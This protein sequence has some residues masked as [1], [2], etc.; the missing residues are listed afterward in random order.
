MKTLISI[1]P[2]SEIII[3]DIVTP[4]TYA[5]SITGFISKFWMTFPRLNMVNNPIARVKLNATISTM[6][7]IP[8]KTTIAPVYIKNSIAPLFIA[9]II[10]S[11]MAFSH[12]LNRSIGF[13]S[14]RSRTKLSGIFI[15]GISPVRFRA[16]LADFIIAVRHQYEYFI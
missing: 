5:Q 3:Y 9:E 15:I 14:T 6:K 11:V 16:S 10:F 1:A 7:I 8:R 12:S 2:S 13:I 4:S